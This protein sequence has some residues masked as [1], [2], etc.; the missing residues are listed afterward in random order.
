MI[1][2]LGYRAIAVVLIVVW[3]SPLLATEPGRVDYG[4]EI[5]PIL[6]SRCFACHGAL[7]QE[8]G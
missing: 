6:K 1:G 5:K 7:K 2:R 4:R 3:G 8:A